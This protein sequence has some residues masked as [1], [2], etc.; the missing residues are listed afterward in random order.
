MIFALM[1]ETRDIAKNTR[2]EVTWT[3]PEELNVS[4][5]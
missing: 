5:N 1:L 4:I 2:T 3:I